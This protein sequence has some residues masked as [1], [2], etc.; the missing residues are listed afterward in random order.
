[1]NIN[2]LAELM[3]KSRS[4][5]T[6]LLAKEDVIELKLTERCVVRK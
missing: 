4:E 3:G 5:I 1:M 6:Q 2:D